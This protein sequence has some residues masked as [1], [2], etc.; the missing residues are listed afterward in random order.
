VST[1]LAREKANL[2]EAAMQHA[3]SDANRDEQ[4]FLDCRTAALRLEQDL[5][6]K[7]RRNQLKNALSGNVAQKAQVPALLLAQ[8]AP[9]VVHAPYKPP[10]LMLMA[11]ASAFVAAVLAWL[12]LNVSEN[13]RVM[14]ATGAI[15]PEGQNADLVAATAVAPVALGDRKAEVMDLLEGWRQAWERRDVK[16]YLMYYSPHFVPANGKTH[17]A[18]RKGRFSNFASRPSISVGIKK[19]QTVLIGSDQFKVFFLQDYKAG[20]YEERDQPKTLLIELRGDKLKIAGE[21]Q[22]HKL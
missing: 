14:P 18:W 21:W 16:A 6:L 15:A 4:N 13:H 8:P 3:H 20:N 19:V 1:T 7:Q 17:D 2:I 12:V 11:C 9:G 5:A 22:G 10:A